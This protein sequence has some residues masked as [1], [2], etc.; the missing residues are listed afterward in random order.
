MYSEKN[1]YDNIINRSLNRVRDDIDKREGS[2]I[3]DAISPIAVELAQAYI[4]I[5]S[6]MDLVFV[7][8]SVGEYLDKLCEQIGIHRK[9]ATKAIR[10]GIFYDEKENKIDVEIGSIFSIDEINYS[11]IEKNDIGEFKLECTAAGKIGNQPLG[12]L[13]PVEYNIKNLG[14]ARITDILVPRRR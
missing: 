3:Y 13:L 14:I 7:D 6:L 4:L 9:V 5:D 11:V 10:K 2:I 8:T 1:T 12:I